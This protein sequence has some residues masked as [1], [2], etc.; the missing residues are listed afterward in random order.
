VHE[1]PWRIIGVAAGIGL[2]AGLLLNRK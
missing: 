1:H 2:L